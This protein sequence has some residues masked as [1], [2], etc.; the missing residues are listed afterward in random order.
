MLITLGGKMPVSW[1]LN[2]KLPYDLLLGIY[3]REVKIYLHTKTY[4]AYLLQAY[5]S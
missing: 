1:K 2:V 4:V 5:S 3:V